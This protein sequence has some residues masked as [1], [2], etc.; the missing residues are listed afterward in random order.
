MKALTI[1][2][3]ASVLL[4]SGCGGCSKS[5]RGIRNKDH[6]TPVKTAG[7]HFRGKT[8]IRMEKE[9]GVYKIPVN[10]NG[11]DMSF[12]FDTGAGMISISNIE[13]SFLYKQGKITM[14]DVI[15]KGN[16]V[17]A[18]GIISEGTI[19]RLKKVTIG[20]RTIYDIEASVVDNSIS[21]LLFGQS[22]LEQFGEIS[23]NY[24]NN[25]ITFE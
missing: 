16:F 10:I 6:S 12:I 8:V 13:A 5:G 18:N 21:P 20:N 4:I 14:E 11:I 17:D 22:A 2:L 9:S 19:I 1:S 25:T 23:I 15:G 3:V 7:N 24:G